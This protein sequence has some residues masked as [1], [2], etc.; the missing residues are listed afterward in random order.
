MERPPVPRSRVR[1]LLAGYWGFGQF[2]GVW[3]I[4]ITAYNGRHGIDDAR[5]GLSLMVLSVAAVR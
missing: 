3:V 4:A 2:W 5:Y 1:A